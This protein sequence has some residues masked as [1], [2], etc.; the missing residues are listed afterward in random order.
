MLSSL[1]SPTLASSSSSLPLWNGMFYSN[2]LH[3]IQES[4]A[5]NCNK[6]NVSLI[7]CDTYI[8]LSFCVYVIHF[9]FLFFFLPSLHPHRS[10]ITHTGLSLYPFFQMSPKWFENVKHVLTTA[11]VTLKFIITQEA[12]L[13]YMWLLFDIKAKVRACFIP[14]VCSSVCV[15]AVFLTASTCMIL[16]IKNLFDVQLNLALP[17]QR[18]TNVHV[19]VIQSSNKRFSLFRQSVLSPVLITSTRGAWQSAHTQKIIYI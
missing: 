10:F 13:H 17:M 14:N 19:Y 1:S 9:F 5:I 3:S 7:L 15:C 12:S 6:L 8:F 18:V 4:S 11:M 16:I 2:R